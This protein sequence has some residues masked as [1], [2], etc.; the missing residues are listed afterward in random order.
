MLS[1]GRGD[2]LRHLSHRQ[3]RDTHR[4]AGIGQG[5]KNIVRRLA[6]SR[7]RL[8][9]VPFFGP[10]IAS[11]V[12]ENSDGHG[13]MVARTRAYGGKTA[14]KKPVAPKLMA[15]FRGKIEHAATQSYGVEKR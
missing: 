15:L 12:A 13:S 6:A 8:A 9:V 14:L 7:L 4:I 1:V 2:S 5:Q 11:L 3:P 10:S